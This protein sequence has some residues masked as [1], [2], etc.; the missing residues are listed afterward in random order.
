MRTKTLL[1]TAALSAAGLATSLAQVYSVNAVGYI[2]LLIPA[3]F[4]MIA[5]QLDKGAGNNTVLNIF[6]TTVPE[7]TTIFKY[8]GTTYEAN[9]FEFGEWALAAQTLN[10]GEGAFIK[11]PGATAFTVT[12]VGEVPQGTLNNAVPAGFS[13]RSSIVPQ[14]A[15]LDPT[16]GFVPSEGDTV[17]QWV[18]A[19]GQYKTASYEFGEW[20]SPSVAVGESFFLKTAAAK[21]WTRTFS[22]N[23][24]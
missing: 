15:A 13:I 7:G 19:T 9:T 21:T 2:N 4:S 22:V 12:L 8:T 14:A 10:P 18:N 17:Y 24:P 5:N 3:G 11:N 6:G 16:L 20:V 23:T 1:L